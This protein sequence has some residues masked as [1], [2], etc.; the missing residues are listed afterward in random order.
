MTWSSR[1]RALL[2]IAGLFT[3]TVLRAQSPVE[4]IGSLPMA[5]SNERLQTSLHL[6]PAVPEPPQPR[7]RR[8]LPKPG[9]LLSPEEVS[10]RDVVR[11]LG[12][13]KH[14]YIHC[15]LP[16]G[17]VRT[18]VITAIGD[19]SFTLKDGIMTNH[20]IHYT[21][22]RTTPRPVA[23]VG[24]RVVHVIRLTGFVVFFPVLVVAIMV[25]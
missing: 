3:S 4:E 15:D 5:L 20:S 23:A 11:K 6:S 16:N 8:R 7:V 18:G 24:T 14:R 12:V 10:Y 21:D 1:L 2:L 22:L 19:D 13:D 25:D 17:R 9:L